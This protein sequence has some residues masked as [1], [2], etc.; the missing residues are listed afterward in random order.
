MSSALKIVLKNAEEFVEPITNN[1]NARNLNLASQ[2]PE[3]CKNEPCSLGID[4][5]G[6]GP[7]LGIRTPINT[8]LPMR[9]FF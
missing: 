3:A 8:R 5:A 9:F 6:R 2:I 1:D 4:E 7:V